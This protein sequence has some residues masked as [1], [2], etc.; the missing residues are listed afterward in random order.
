MSFRVY[1]TEQAKLDIARNADWWA[2]H[3]CVDQAVGW[4]ITIEKQLATLAEMPTRFAVAPENMHF[5][6]ELRQQPVGVGAVKTYRALFRIVGKEVHVL[7]IRAAQQDTV[8]PDDLS[9]E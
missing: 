5:P 6:F 8:R 9:G 3:H 4:A 7:A 1:L 2:N